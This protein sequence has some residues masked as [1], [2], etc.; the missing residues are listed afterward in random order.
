MI[1]LAVQQQDQGM[2]ITVAPITHRTPA[3]HTV[4][5]ELPCRVKQHLGL[6]HEQSWIVLSEVNQFTWPGY[7]VRP[8]RGNPERFEYGFLPPKLFQRIRA[9]MLDLISKRRV[10]ISDRDL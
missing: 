9:M 2:P 4:G 6:D 10:Q 7:D 1:V 3:G 8:I 5:L